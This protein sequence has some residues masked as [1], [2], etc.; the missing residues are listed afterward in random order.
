MRAAC[1]GLEHPHCRAGWLA[2]CRA[3]LCSEANNMSSFPSASADQ[4]NPNFGTRSRAIGLRDI[5]PAAVD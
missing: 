3:M 2:T 1:T 4:Q 5:A